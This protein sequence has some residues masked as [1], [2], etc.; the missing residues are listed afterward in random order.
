M[1]EQFI[2]DKLIIHGIHHSNF[3][4]EQDKQAF[5]YWM[6]QLQQFK[7]LETVEEAIEYFF[8]NEGEMVAA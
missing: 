4:R 8:A 6:H 1:S 7:G 5:T 3:G 2:I